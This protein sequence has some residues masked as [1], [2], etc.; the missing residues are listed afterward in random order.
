MALRADL[1]KYFHR[2]ALGEHFWYECYF[3][4]FVCSFLLEVNGKEGS[5]LGTGVHF[6]SEV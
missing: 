3:T 6:M 5:E 4:Q 1:L 2:D